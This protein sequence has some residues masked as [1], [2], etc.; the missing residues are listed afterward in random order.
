MDRLK[1]FGFLLKDVSRLFIKRFEERAAVGLSLTLGQ[2]K[3]L[4]TLFKNEGISQKR[5]SEL[6]DIEPMTLVRILDCMEAAGFIERRADPADRRARTLYLTKKAAPI[7]DRIWEVSAQTRQETLAGFSTEERN[8]LISL[9]E[10]AH[11]NLLSLKPIADSPQSSPSRG[12]PT[13]KPPASTNRKA[14]A[15]R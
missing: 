11:E 3:A 2:C 9:F 15:P 5:L 6:A 12:A 7:L 14:A 10:R 13:T 4:I 1:N 8:T